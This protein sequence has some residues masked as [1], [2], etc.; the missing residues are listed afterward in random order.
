MKN[1]IILISLVFCLVSNSFG[2]SCAEM[3][4]KF[5]SVIQ[6]QKVKICRIAGLEKGRSDILGMYFKMG[7]VDA[8]L[9]YGSN[10]PVMLY[11]DNDYPVKHTTCIENNDYRAIQ[12]FMSG[13]QIA[14]KMMSMKTCE[15]GYVSK[16]ERGYSKIKSK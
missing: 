13:D 3:H 15:A 14:A 16:H 12:T 10:Y 4:A 6:P 5:A 9:V 2:S 11:I 7:T 1:I 8:L